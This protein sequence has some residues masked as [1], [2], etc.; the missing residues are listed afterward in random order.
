MQ[1]IQVCPAGSGDIRQSHHKSTA[2]LEPL[3]KGRVFI[4][5][6]GPQQEVICMPQGPRG[7]STCKGLISRVSLCMAEIPPGQE[8]GAPWHWAATGRTCS[9]AFSLP[10]QAALASLPAAA[11]KRDS[12]PLSLGLKQSYCLIR[13]CL[14]K[15]TV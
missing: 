4:W 15:I 6:R 11:W 3:E 1:I 9:A 12:A 7:S 14:A 13:L 10:D 8:E 2:Q 5:L